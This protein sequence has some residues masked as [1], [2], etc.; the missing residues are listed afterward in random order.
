MFNR[1]RQNLSPK[2]QPELIRYRIRLARILI[3]TFFILLVGWL[4]AAL[5]SK[6]ILGAEYSYPFA[7][8][9]ASIA[10]LSL[11]GAGALWLTSHQRLGS[12]GYLLASTFFV[13]ATLGLV[14]FAQ[15]FYV[16]SATYLISIIT[17]GAIIGGGSTYLFAFTGSIAISLH[18]FNTWG[19]GLNPASGFEPASSLLILGSQ[20]VLFFGT[21]AILYSLS[22]Q[23]QRTIDHLHEQADRL[24]DLAQTDPLTGLPNRR[25]FIEILE[26]EFNRARRYHRP[27]SLLYLDLDEFKELNDRHGHLFGDEILRGSSRSLKSVLRS[28][29]LLARIGG[30]EFA[31]L[32]PETN[33]G[34]AQNVARKLRRALIAFGQQISPI[35]PP[36]TFCGGI[37]QLREAD[38]SIDDM[39]ARADSAQYLAKDMGK[40][41]TRTELDLESAPRFDV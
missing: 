3:I 33:L 14:L 28:T 29:D 35:V 12:A 24:V 8:D 25:Y 32:L 23:V 30:D 31:V 11:F 7:L 20:I 40:D 4:I 5:I 13:S 2:I 34:D 38:G 26:R 18:W 27:L 36:L 19:T 9:I 15:A 41:D 37:S 21:A 6:V 16:M 22:N 39:L 1:L 10:V 17:A